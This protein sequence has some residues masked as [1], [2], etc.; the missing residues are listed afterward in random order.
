MFTDFNRYAAEANYRIPV[1][2][3]KLA[4]SIYHKGLSFVKTLGDLPPSAFLITHD[5]F[6]IVPINCNNYETKIASLTALKEMTKNPHIEAII[7]AT[8]GWMIVESIPEGLQEREKEDL[9]KTILEHPIRPSTHPNRIEVVN[10]QV[11]IRNM[12]EEFLALA[13]IIRKDGEVYI[14]P[15]KPFFVSNKDYKGLFQGIFV[16]EKHEA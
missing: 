2:I 15:N 5:S 13:E 6:A 10:F 16:R 11:S 1:R 4:E 8:G 14:H 3:R 7:I 12:D 9:V